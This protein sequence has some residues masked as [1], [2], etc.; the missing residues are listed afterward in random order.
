MLELADWDGYRLLASPS[1]GRM[2]PVVEKLAADKLIG[3]KG[4]G[5]SGVH[6]SE[7]ILAASGPSVKTGS[8]IENARLVD[9]CPTALA[10]LGL[11]SPPD[12]DGH[13][14]WQIASESAVEGHSPACSKQ[15]SETV[16]SPEEEELVLERLKG[17][18]YL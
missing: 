1:A 11:R 8:K 7:G 10:L 13:N 6:R 9:I 4:T 15:A 17:L 14:L 12:L 2:G 18:G 16:Y 5:T 3:S